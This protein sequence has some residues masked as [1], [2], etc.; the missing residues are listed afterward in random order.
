[1]H[2]N[3]DLISCDHKLTGKKAIFHFDVSEWL[4]RRRSDHLRGAMRRASETLYASGKRPS[5]SENYELAVSS[6]FWFSVSARLS[7]VPVTLLK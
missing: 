7:V 3:L 2:S 1:M 5:L 6:K 4:S